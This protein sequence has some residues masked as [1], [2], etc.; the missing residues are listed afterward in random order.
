MG[1]SCKFKHGVYSP[2]RLGQYESHMDS[3]QEVEHS[4]D[5]ESYAQANH[6]PSTRGGAQGGL[7]SMQGQGSSRFHFDIYCHA[8]SPSDWMHA[9]FDNQATAALRLTDAV[10]QRVAQFIEEKPAVADL[11]SVRCIDLMTSFGGKTA[12]KYK[13]SLEQQE[14]CMLHFVDRLFSDSGQREEV[15]NR[16]W[17]ATA[18]CES[19][20]QLSK[21][22]E[23]ALTKKKASDGLQA[24]LASPNYEEIT[25]KAKEE[26]I[27]LSH[28]A[29]KD[30][31]GL[32]PRFE[33]LIKLLRVRA[34]SLSLSLSLSSDC[35]QYMSCAVRR[36]CSGGNRRGRATT[37]D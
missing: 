8:R 14:R 12:K 18:I 26:F 11:L 33:A 31:D 28:E 13:L 16:Q 3:V 29:E 9:Q 15:K 6:E 4:H 27:R 20:E 10:C 35:S 32:Y 17:W 7:Q 23:V 22:R 34:L 21:V 25:E 37:R 30:E 1:V 36:P 2:N 19:G 5:G 24:V